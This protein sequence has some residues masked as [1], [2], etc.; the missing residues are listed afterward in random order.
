[1]KLH[2]DAK[3]EPWVPWD[4]ELWKASQKLNKK[5]FE[6]T[7]IEHDADVLLME[8]EL[9]FDWRPSSDQKY[10]ILVGTIEEAENALACV[11]PFRENVTILSDSVKVM[12]YL[13]G[14]D[15][16]SARWNV[17][18]RITE[19]FIY[20]DHMD[21]HNKTGGFV[22]TCN[23]SRQEDNL[24]EILKTYFA[25]CLQDDKQNEGELKLLHDVDIFSAQELPFETF[26][27]VTFHGLQPNPKMFKMIKNAKLFV[28]PYR[29]TGVPINAIDAWMLGTPAIVRDT[30]TNRAIF[31]WSDNC[32]FNDE[33]ELAQKIKFFSE[34]PVNDPEYIR[35]VDDGFNAVKA[36]HYVS[37]SLLALIYILQG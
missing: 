32:F 10:L 16:V 28:S 37:N 26:N 12:D 36:S 33:K 35:M 3:A 23:G 19:R 9:K 15:F 14:E 5:N 7:S 4:K 17:P 34:M 18:S 22:I 13:K 2:I 27:N 6:I 20:K 24:T 1:M 21:T 8:W 11:A 31:N 30:E 25:I 29:G